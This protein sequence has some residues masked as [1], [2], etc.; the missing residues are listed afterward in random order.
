MTKLIH[1]TYVCIDC[2]STGLDVKNDHIIEIAAAKF[3]DGEIIESFSSLIDPKCKIPL[4][5]QEIHHIS[6]EMVK[7]KPTI[8]KVLPSFFKFIKDYTIVGHGILFD[9]Q[10][11]SNSAKKH[12]L[13]TSIEKTTF[14]DTLRLARLYG[15]APVNSLEQ[16]R[17]HFNVP[18]EGAHRALNDVL[19]N[20]AVFYHLTSFYKNSK[21]LFIK[22]QK[23]IL[24][25]NMPLG[26]HKGRPFDEVPIEYLYWAAK[27]D[28]DLDL[29]YSIRKAIKNRKTRNLFAHSG[30]PFSD[31]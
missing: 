7:G 3:K 19:V 15:K 13:L 24:L 1:D 23:P 20:I 28:F 31:L 27:K 2:E 26:K 22:L 11:I 17:K 12:G 18:E 21:E 30:N 8:D 9:I 4:E 10:I 16:L 25:K 29:S 6:D 14:L 5:S